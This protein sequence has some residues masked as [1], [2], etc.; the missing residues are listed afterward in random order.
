MGARLR[1]MI[2]GRQA[3]TG[4]SVRQIFGHFDRRG[5][6]YVNAGEIQDA[7]TDLRFDVSP[8][9]AKEFL[10]MIAL[11]GGDR[12][13]YGEFA[14]FV[15]DPYHAELQDEV[16]CQ[17]AERLEALGQVS[18]HLDEAFRRK[19]IAQA[20]TAGSRYRLGMLSADEF[21]VGLEN[22][23]IRLSTS[24]AQR[25][26]VRFDIHGDGYISAGRFVSM[27]ECSIPWKRARAHLTRQDE[28]D[29]EADAWLRT[30][31][32]QHMQRAV[33]T[34]DKLPVPGNP[35]RLSV[36]MVEMARYLG[37]RISSDSSL[38]WIASDALA[39]PLPDGWVAQKTSGG[40]SFYHNE[41]TG[42]S[43][44]DH[45]LDPHFRRL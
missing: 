11:D 6:G 35:L 41:R 2:L 40:R 4:R 38:L 27:V 5:C 45:P 36:E 18:F 33:H 29:E 26:I 3:S 15:S 30:R 24:N 39:A 9:E 22:L 8:S 10:R 13:S 32:V 14:V 37:I 7:L 25:L 19:A 28:A 44:W 16:C 23:G 12:V 34:G 42:Q 21:L 1:Q 17:A 43:R 31:H 20:Q